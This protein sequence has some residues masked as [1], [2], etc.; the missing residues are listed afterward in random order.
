MTMAPSATLKVPGLIFKNCANSKMPV[1]I[2]W[3]RPCP[4]YPWA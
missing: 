1:K 2:N 4:S 3:E